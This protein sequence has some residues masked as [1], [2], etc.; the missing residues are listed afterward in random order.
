MSTYQYRVVPAPSKGVKTKGIKGAEARFSNTIEE[1]MNQM[2]SDG[3]EYQRAEMLPSVERAGLTGTTTQWRNVL[4]FRKPRE[5]DI[6]A[7]A[8][9]L[10]AAPISAGFPPVVGPSKAPEIEVVEATEDMHQ[11]GGEYAAQS[12]SENSVEVHSEVA[13]TTD[14]FASLANRRSLDNSDS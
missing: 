2:G 12:L 11:T 5:T 3:W 14:A 8:P 6:A 1:L 7:A 9:A 4:V 10:I 13:E